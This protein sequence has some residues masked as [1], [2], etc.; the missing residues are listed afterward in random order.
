MRATPPPA[1]P[2][3]P[4]AAP[5]AAPPA[6][7]H[8]RTKDRAVPLV[9]VDSYEVVS[10]EVITATKAIRADDPYLEGHYPDFAIYPGVFVV[11]SVTQTVRILAERTFRTPFE[12]E[13]AAITSVRFSRPMLPGD[14]LHVRCEC[15]LTRPSAEPAAVGDGP[16]APAPVRDGL[17]TVRAECR[18]GAGEK[19]ARLTLEFRL[20]EEEVDGAA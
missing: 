8:R 16:A 3:I 15:T 4:D 1:P 18:N 12:L 7:P 11:E 13:L 5:P 20:T 14:T 17:L 2:A 9:A 19:A 10:P 6:T